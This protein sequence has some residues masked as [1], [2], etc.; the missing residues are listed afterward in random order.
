MI[1]AIAILDDPFWLTIIGLLI[2]YIFSLRRRMAGLNDP[3]LW[4]SRKERRLYAVKQL[5]AADEERELAR[6]QKNLDIVQG[7]TTTH[8]EIA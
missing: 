5:E 2:V 7:T 6:F 4:L 1:K 8:K 3:R